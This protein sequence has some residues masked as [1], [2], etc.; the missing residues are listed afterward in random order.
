[1]YASLQLS[2][3]EKFVEELAGEVHNRLVKVNRKGK[4]ISLKVKVRRQDAPTETAKFLGRMPHLS[5][6]SCFGSTNKHCWVQLPIGIE[7]CHK[8]YVF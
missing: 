4:Q 1:M 6:L 8:S 7:D 5:Y 2:E 3:V